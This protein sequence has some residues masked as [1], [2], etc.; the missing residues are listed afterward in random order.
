MTKAM[1]SVRT[2]DRLRDQLLGTVVVHKRLFLETLQIYLL[3]DPEGDRAEAMEIWC[4]SPW[5]LLGDDAVLADSMLMYAERGDPDPAQRILSQAAAILVGR[6]VEDLV[7]EPPTQ[8]LRV[9]FDG[10][11]ELR[12]APSED[13]TAEQWL[14]R[15]PSRRP[16][17]GGCEEGIYLVE[18][19]EK[20]RRITGSDI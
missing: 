2:F 11:L 15:G 8:R 9:L 10:G 5:Q 14:L 16:E 18:R 6:V 4:E 20:G 13:A 19:N 7:V 12:T 17:V 1:A 3:V